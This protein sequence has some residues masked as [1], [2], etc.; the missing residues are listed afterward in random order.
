MKTPLSK[1]NKHLVWY[2]RRESWYATA[3]TILTDNASAKQMNQNICHSVWSTHHIASM[4]RC[5]C[6]TWLCWRKSQKVNS[7]QYFIAFR[8]TKT[9]DRTVGRLNSSWNSLKFWEGI[10]LRLW[11]IPGNFNYTFIAL[12]PKVDNPVSLNDF[13]TISLC[14]C[15]YKVVTKVIARCLKGILSDR[16]TEEQFWISRGEA[17]SW[18]HWGRS[19]RFA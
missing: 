13:R 18:G 7:R 17:D 14:N 10:Y 15:I 12:I 11:R 16:I 1:S 9:L 19:R 4:P 3:P 8:R 6:I 2:A 5:S